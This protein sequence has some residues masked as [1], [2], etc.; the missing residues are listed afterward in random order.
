MALSR[1][2]CIFAES[3]DGL[4]SLQIGYCQ[5]GERCRRNHGSDQKG[6]EQTFSTRYRNGNKILVI[7]SVQGHNS[8]R[9]KRDGKAHDLSCTYLR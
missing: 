9:S 4:F 3:V 1:R 6:G 2:G 5:R 7:A 8:A